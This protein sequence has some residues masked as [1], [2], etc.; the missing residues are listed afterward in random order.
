MESRHNGRKLLLGLFWVE[1]TSAGLLFWFL[2]ELVG[3]G[4]P[5][6]AGMVRWWP[7][8]VLYAV[9]LVFAML[10]AGLYSRHLRERLPGILLRLLL[11]VVLAVAG[12]AL[13]SSTFTGR[14]AVSGLLMLGITTLVLLVLVRGAFLHL[15]AWGWLQRRAIVLGAGRRALELERLRRRTDLLGLRIVGYVP[16]PGEVRRVS[17]ERLLRS[18]GGLLRLA[19]RQGAEQIIVAADER[20]Q[21]LPNEQLVAARTAGLHIVDLMDFLEEELGKIKLELLR[22]SWL[23][24]GGG[25]Q[26]GRGAAAAKRL[27]DILVSLLLLGLAAPLMILAAVAVLIES[28]RPVIY[29]QARVGRG[30]RVFQLYKFRSMRADAEKGGGAQW[31]RTDDDRVTRVGRVLRRYR[32]DEL[33]QLYNVLRGEM[34]FVGPR[35][36]RPEFVKELSA[37]LPYYQE[38]HRV[39]PGL[40]GW[41]QIRYHYGASERDAF[42]KLQYDLFY[43]KHQGVWLDVAILLQTAEVVLWGRGAR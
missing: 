25:F 33:P 20:R 34:S 41:A 3:S 31:A 11:S 37:S 9:L 26:G 14:V 40:T 2:R 29:R 7:Q 8:A 1:I 28:G 22:P 4:V 23:I 43:V 5:Q 13:L 10:G 32:I 19:R 6:V 42:E 36:E 17:P 24:F 21:R 30:G 35:P 38:R 27:L 12:W 18:Q 16:L 15:S 39:K